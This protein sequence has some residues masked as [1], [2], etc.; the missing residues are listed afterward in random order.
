MQFDTRQFT[1]KE[2][3]AITNSFEKSI[4]KGGFGVVYLGYLEDGT[5]VAVKTRSESSSQGINEFLGEVR[6]I[7]IHLL[8]IL[9]YLFSL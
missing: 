5:P 1:Y 4:G 8:L 7:P 3:K 2:L 6:F 9:Q